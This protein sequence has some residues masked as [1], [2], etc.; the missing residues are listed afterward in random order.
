MIGRSIRHTCVAYSALAG[1]FG[2]LHV[3]RVLFERVKVRNERF[4]MKALM[5][6]E[7]VI[8]TPSEL[9]AA[10][11]RLSEWPLDHAQ[12]AQR[13]HLSCGGSKGRGGVVGAP[14][15]PA[16]LWVF[17][18]RSTGK[19]AGEHYYVCP[20][21]WDGAVRRAAGGGGGRRRGAGGVTMSQEATAFGAKPGL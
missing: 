11:A 13:R 16:G 15:F 3:S 12:G 21:W 7:A 5:Y 4:A 8:L 18:L 17:R 9:G 10:G 20:V 1:M 14:H 2:P 19:G 6:S